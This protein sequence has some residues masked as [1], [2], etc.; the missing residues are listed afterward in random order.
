MFN[1]VKKMK[2]KG[3]LCVFAFEKFSNWQLFM[4]PLPLLIFLDFRLVGLIFWEP[5]S[6]W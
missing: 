5:T 4:R 2:Q 6:T 3:V 1:L